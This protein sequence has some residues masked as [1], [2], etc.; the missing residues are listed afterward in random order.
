MFLQVMLRILA[1][2]IKRKDTVFEVL[3]KLRK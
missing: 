2:E 3:S 1:G